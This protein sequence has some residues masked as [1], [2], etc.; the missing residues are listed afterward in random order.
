MDNK[1]PRS[2]IKSFSIYGLFGTQDVH[3]DFDENIK[4]IIG[5]N[6]LGKTQLLN[7]IYYLLFAYRKF[8]QAFKFS[9]I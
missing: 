5:E 3:I 1:S 6:G 2:I 8:F 4:I 7:I 9:I